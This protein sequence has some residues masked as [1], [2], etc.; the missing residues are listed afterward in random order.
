[1]A[2]VNDAAE[3]QGIVKQL[4]T[5]T[6]APYWVGGHDSTLEGTFEWTT[7]EPWTYRLWDAGEPNNDDCGTLDQD[8]VGLELD[9]GDLDGDFNDHCCDQARRFVCEKPLR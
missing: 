4:A 3:H 2:A 8:C 7:G 5:L 1:L 9:S 6:P